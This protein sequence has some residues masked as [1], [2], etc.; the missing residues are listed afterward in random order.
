MLNYA[1]LYRMVW[2]GGRFGGGKT[3]LAIAIAIW[4]C[5]RNYARFIASNIPLQVGREVGRVSATELRRIT[6]EGPVYRDTVILMDEA[7]IQLGK[8]AGRKQIVEWL[9]YMR[10]GNNFLVMP[11]VIPLVAEVATLR[12]ERIFNGMVFGVPGWLYKWNLGDY[13][14]GGDRGI[15]WFNNPQSVFPLYDTTGIPLDG[16]IIYEVWKDENKKQIA[17][18][19]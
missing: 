17:S 7:W 12:V 6:C 14:K 13:R 15:Y 16:F 5:Q 19:S 18:G 3:S 11:S 2:I 9:S 10:K 4:L 8:G 1:W